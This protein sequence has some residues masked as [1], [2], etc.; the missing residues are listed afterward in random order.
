M[1]SDGIA[2]LLRVMCVFS[3]T[4]HVECVACSKELLK[5]SSAAL[6]IASVSAM[7]G[8]ISGRLTVLACALA[9]GLVAAFQPV[10]NAVD[11]GP[12]DNDNRGYA[13]E[14]GYISGFLDTWMQRVPDDVPLWKL[15]VPG[16]HDSLSTG[17][18]GSL[19][20][21]QSR[22][23][24]DQLASG[25]RFLDLRFKLGS[26]G[27]LRAQHGAVQLEGTIA[28]AFRTITDFLVAHPSEVVI[29]RIK[30]E[31]SSYPSDQYE[32]AIRTWLEP[33]EARLATVSQVTGTGA[34]T[35]MRLG[36]LRGKVV[37]MPEVGTSTLP[38][39]V[40]YGTHSIVQDDWNVYNLEGLYPKWETIKAFFS[41]TAAEA[42][43]Q[44]SSPRLYINYLSGSSSGGQVHPHTVA[45]GQGSAGTWD[46][47]LATGLCGPAFASRYPDFDRSNG[48]IYYTGMN[49]LAPNW[50]SVN[51]PGTAGI[52]VADYPGPTLVRRVVDLNARYL[53]KPA[54][55][56]RFNI[57]SN[58]TGQHVDV[59]GG[60]ASDG[61]QVVQW[62]DNGGDNQKWRFVAAPQGINSYQVVS[63]SSGKCLTIVGASSANGAKLEQRGCA[64]PAANHQVWTLRLV[65]GTSAPSTFAAGA[66]NLVDNVSRKCVAIPGGSW[67]AGEQLVIWDCVGQ[68]DTVWRMKRVS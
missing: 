19:A 62:P 42:A 16:T 39:G 32:S 3:M 17:T 11:G 65:P 7:S 66:Y 18:G 31:D 29:T 55:A 15:S 9:C 60:S 67:A 26:D 61:A 14:S 5:L 25:I 21:T 49:K 50:L 30:Q 38:Y 40:P 28:D 47:E 2:R 20:Q 10:T 4:H 53:P 52:V 22:S 44:Q 27:V 8:L 68:A 36:N 63:V 64:S 43:G 51:L 6:A 33:Y 57:V 35:F 24:A 54:A 23:L 34:A 46:G 45:S 1:R 56:D 48:C 59:A 12:N 41:R 37:V 13:K 58:L